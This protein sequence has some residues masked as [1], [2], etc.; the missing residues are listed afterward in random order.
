MAYEVIFK[1]RFL[2]SLEK[3]LTYL[4]KEWGNEVASNFLKIIYERIDLLKSQ[5]YIGMISPKIT[6]VR[7][8]LVKKH[9]RLFYKISNSKIIFLNMYD[10]RIK[11]SKN[12]FN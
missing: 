4:E 8:I 9:N 3:V 2:N 11:P 6:N 10:T 5:P 12:P 7:G 1:K